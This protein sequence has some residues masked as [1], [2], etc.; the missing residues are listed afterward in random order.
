MISEQMA[1]VKVL[2]LI[3]FCKNT[4]CLYCPFSDG[5]KD[6]DQVCKIG[7]PRSWEGFRNENS[8]GTGQGPDDYGILQTGMS[9][10]V[11]VEIL[12]D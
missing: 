3:D 2:A 12:P 5:E 6:N 4:G 1:R 11:N 9:E 8:N 7:K 10:T